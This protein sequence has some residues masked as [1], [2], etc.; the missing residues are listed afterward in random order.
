[1]TAMVEDQN[2]FQDLM[3]LSE[4]GKPKNSLENNTFAISLQQEDQ[5]RRTQ[6]EF[7]QSKHSD[8]LDKTEKSKIKHQNSF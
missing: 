2:E 7:D 1:M 5:F 4:A 3:L 6:G 8:F